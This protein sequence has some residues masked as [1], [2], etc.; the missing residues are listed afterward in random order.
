MASVFPVNNVNLFPYVMEDGLRDRPRPLRGH[1]RHGHRKDV[2]KQE[3]HPVFRGLPR[4]NGKV[5]WSSVSM[6]E[7]QQQDRETGHSRLGFRPSCL[8]TLARD[9]L[10]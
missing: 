3:S 9:V 4:R 5:G 1:D 7:R 2:C 10:L 8:H 6:I